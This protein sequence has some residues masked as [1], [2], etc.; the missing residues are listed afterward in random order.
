MELG[1]KFNPLCKENSRKSQQKECGLS[2]K[3]L[4]HLLFL[5]S[6][7]E[8]FQVLFEASCPEMLLIF[9]QMFNFTLSQILISH[10]LWIARIL[11]NKQYS[12]LM[13]C[14]LSTW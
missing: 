10:P 7:F 1:V 2:V 6:L 3:Y 4:L 9:I 14:K 8:W 13:Y 12:Y 5:L 11:S